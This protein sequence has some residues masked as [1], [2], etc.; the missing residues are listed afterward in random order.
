MDVLGSVRQP[1]TFRMLIWPEASNAQNSIAAVSADGSTV[2]PSLELFVQTLDRIGGSDAAICLLPR[3]STFSWQNTSDTVLCTVAS[4]LWPE[5]AQS[6]VGTQVTPAC[7]PIADMWWRQPK[8]RYSLGTQR[9]S[10]RGSLNAPCPITL[11][12]R[13]APT[14]PPCTRDTR[15][16]QADK[17]FRRIIE[18]AD[19]VVGL[20]P[21]SFV[22]NKSGREATSVPRLR[23]D[24]RTGYVQGTDVRPARA[25]ETANVTKHVKHPLIAPPYRQTNPVRRDVGG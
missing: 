25:R 24:P 3:T 22:K 21:P 15:L 11:P 14:R 5:M 23:R 4:G 1:S 9:A 18:V 19:D 12:I 8:A 13:G 7:Q 6:I 20:W 2:D 17:F 10:F 16:A